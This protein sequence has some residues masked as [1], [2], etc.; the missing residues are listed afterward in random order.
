MGSNQLDKVFQP[1]VSCGC[2]RTERR[3]MLRRSLH[4]F[5]GGVAPRERLCAERNGARERVELV[6]RLLASPSFVPKIARWQ[7][8]RRAKDRARHIRNGI[9]DLFPQREAA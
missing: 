9:A 3:P 5:P 8:N 6:E 2:E 4:S 1:Y 7:S